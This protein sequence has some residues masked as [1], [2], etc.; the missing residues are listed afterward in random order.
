MSF[1]EGTSCLGKGYNGGFYTVKAE[2]DNE[3]VTLRE[4]GAIEI[5]VGACQVGASFQWL[6]ALVGLGEI[7][8][9]SICSYFLFEDD[10]K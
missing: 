4:W 6:E 2:A 10:E 9:L 1:Q 8:L 5:C 3:T 7:T